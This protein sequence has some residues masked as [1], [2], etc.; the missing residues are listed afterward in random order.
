MSDRS[1]HSSLLKKNKGKVTMGR[2]KYLL[3]IVCKHIDVR[4]I[5]FP[6]MVISSLIML[7][8]SNA[9]T[10]RRDK[11]ILY[12]RVVIQNLIMISILAFNNLHIKGLG[13]GIGVYGG[14]FNISVFSQTF[15]LFI[16]FITS[17]ILTLTAFYPRKVYITGNESV[18]NF[19]MMK[20]LYNKNLISNKVGEQFRIIEYP[21]IIL[22]VVCG[23]I[24]LISTGDLIS[25]FLSIELQSYG[26]YI[27]CT[28][29]RDSES[30]TAS[31]LTYF[32]LG[33]LSS[34]FILLGSGLL[35]IN[36]GA[37]NLDNIYVIASISEMGFHTLVPYNLYFLNMNIA[38]II[39]FTGFL[40]K[41]SAAPFHF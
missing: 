19:L 30:S 3:N 24:F 16:F 9:V 20:L 7:L 31:G 38:F 2:V 17:L 5:S 28:L 10:L 4:I 36:S 34:C 6:S 35:Y 14:L 29:Y 12:S 11:S 27:I 37:T 22:F 15:N 41:V 23:A 1:R 13:N 33:G 40:F 8:I 32:L 39:M 21:L 25:I 18:Y 26:L